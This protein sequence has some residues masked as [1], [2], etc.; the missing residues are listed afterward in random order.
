MPQDARSLRLILNGKASGNPLIRPA[1]EK[2]RQAGFPLEVRVTWESGDA[3]RFAHEACRD[4]VDVVIVGGGDGSV[5]EVAGGVLEADPESRSALAVLPLGTAND[6]ATGCG[7]PTA[8]PLAALRL[9]AEG[10]IAPI[11]VGKVNGRVFVNVASAG[12]G[13]AVTTQTPKELKDA[14]GG[15]AYALMGLVSFLKLQ[16]YHGEATL[17]DGSKRKGNM[18]LAAIC[19]ARL[20]GGGFQVGPKALLDDGLLDVMIIH[21]FPGYDFGALLQEL[22]ELREDGR[23]VSYKQIPSFHVE[24]EEDLQV[25]ADGEPIVGRSFHFEAVPKA[26]S[27]VLPPGA[28]LRENE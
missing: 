15:A 6:F 12:F 27:F 18:I 4:G 9:A 14:I 20:A 17:P 8:D 22:T 19:N 10:K 25:N 7:I 13:A 2:I 26:L 24:V 23:Y 5:N 16:P 1:V 21:D 28:P 11:D 3:A